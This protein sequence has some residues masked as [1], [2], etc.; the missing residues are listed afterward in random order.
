MSTEH[1]TE[2]RMGSGEMFD[3]IAARYDML[4]RILSMGIDKRWRRLTVEALEL[5]QGA[6]V[7]DLAT[8][9]ADLAIAI[10]RRH[11]DATVVGTDP[12]SQ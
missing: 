11:P 2:T 1:G 4:N 3:A 12:S 9:T 10:A 7:L 5:G 8:G 6:R